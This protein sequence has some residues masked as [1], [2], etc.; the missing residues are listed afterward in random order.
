MSVERNFLRRDRI[1]FRMELSGSS[2]SIFPCSTREYVI[3]GNINSLHENSFLYSRVQR[4]NMNFTHRNMNS[5]HGN[6]NST[7]GNMNSTH[8]NVNSTHGNT[9]LDSRVLSNR[10]P[11]CHGETHVWIENPIG[12]LVLDKVFSLGPG[13]A[14]GS[15]STPFTGGHYP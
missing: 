4:G 8:G 11:C 9:L 3:H 2:R 12:G 7:H 10:I 6:M 5:T 1:S 13:V 14:P 15:F